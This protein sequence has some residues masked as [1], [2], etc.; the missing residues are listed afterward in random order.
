MAAASKDTCACMA[1]I[2]TCSLVTLPGVSVHIAGRTAAQG[3][4]RMQQSL[5]LYDT[6]L[7]IEI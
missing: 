3:R 4:I 6:V 7:P 2:G 5:T 1:V